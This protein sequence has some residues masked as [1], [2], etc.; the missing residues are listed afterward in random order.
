ML[1][2]E[3]KKKNNTLIDFFIQMD[4]EKREAHQIFNKN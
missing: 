3:E 2:N 4:K 1:E